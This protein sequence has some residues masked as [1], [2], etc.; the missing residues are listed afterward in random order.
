MDVLSL[1]ERDRTRPLALRSSVMS[2]TPL[3][4]AWR[5]EE[6]LTVLPSMEM[7]PV[8]GRM[9]PKSALK[10]SLRPEPMRPKIPRISACRTSRSIPRNMPRFVSPVTWRAISAVGTFSLTN[11]SS[12]FRPII[13]LM[14]PVRVISRIGFV[15]MYLPSRRTVTASA[16]VKISFKRWDT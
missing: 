7:R 16:M 12:N 14:S 6:K 2:A 13:M 15:P 4:M 11:S 8:S 9:E 5:G 3:S 1:T 10:N